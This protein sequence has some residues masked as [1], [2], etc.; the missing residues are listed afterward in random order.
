MVYK[1]YIKRGGKVFGPYYYES[2]RDKNGRVKTRF[3][4]G[5]GKKDK[6]A[7]I[8]K[9]RKL[10]IYLLGIFFILFWLVFFAIQID[11]QDVVNDVYTGRVVTDPYNDFKCDFF[12]YHSSN[13]LN[14]EEGLYAG[15]ITGED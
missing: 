10:L 6:L 3:I 5:P 8:M 13:C 14:L 11:F 1:K 7:D 9:K 2:Y 12:C 15:D 4:S